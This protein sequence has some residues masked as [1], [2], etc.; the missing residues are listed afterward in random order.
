MV[1]RCTKIHSIVIGIYKKD[2]LG[3]FVLYLLDPKIIVQYK[4]INHA[5]KEG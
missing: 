4:D 5:S 3:G 1:C 2:T